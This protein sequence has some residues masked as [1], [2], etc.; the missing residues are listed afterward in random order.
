MLKRVGEH[1]YP[2]AMMDFGQN[3]ILDVDINTCDWPAR[4]EL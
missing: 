1:T 2:E 3:P 4:D